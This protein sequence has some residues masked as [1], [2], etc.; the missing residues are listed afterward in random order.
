MNTIRPY[1]AQDHAACLALF[2]SNVPQ[3]FDHSER[4]AFARFLERDAGAWHYLVIVRAGAVVACG[5][6]ALNDD[7][8]VAGF[9]WGMVDRRLHRQGLGRALTEA[10]LDACRRSGVARIELDT[11]QHTQ[12]FY[13]RF[14]FAVERVVANGYGPGLDRWDMALDLGYARD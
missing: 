9:G 7:G 13:A 1:A 5:G 3:F 14:G 6:H 8:R 11:S 2:D 4:A 12:A 10:R